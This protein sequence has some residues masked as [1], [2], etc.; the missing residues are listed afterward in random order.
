MDA[1][2]IF[3][4]EYSKRNGA[5]IHIC[6]YERLSSK[7]WISFRVEV[8][9][10]ISWHLFLAKEHYFIFTVLIFVTALYSNTIL[11]TLA[12]TSW[13][14]RLLMSTLLRKNACTM[15]IEGVYAHTGLHW[16]YWHCGEVNPGLLVS[17][18]L[19]LLNNHTQ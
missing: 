19:A 12:S 16:I 1:D 13:K 4:A 9:K 5:V 15:L 11:S 3:R 10:N 6:F 18:E 8:V 7:L 17:H 14:E 2:L